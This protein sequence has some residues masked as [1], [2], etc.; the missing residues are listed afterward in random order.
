MLCAESHSLS[1][2][3]YRNKIAVTA[4]CRAGTA[5]RNGIVS[6]ALVL[7]FQKSAYLSN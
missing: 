3:L 6:H 1:F 4:S 2:T 5:V 7:L